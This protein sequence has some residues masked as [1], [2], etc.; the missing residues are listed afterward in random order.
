MHSTLAASPGIPNFVSPVCLPEFESTL[1][2]AY[3]AQ[4]KGLFTCFVLFA[5]FTLYLALA[6]QNAMSIA[7]FTITFL[8]VVAIAFDAL[9]LLRDTEALK[10]RARFFCWIQRSPAGRR[11]AHLWLSL[12]ISLGLLQLILQAHYGGHEQLVLALG[13]HF[14]SIRS[15]QYWRTLTGPYFHSG[16][17]HFVNNAILLMFIGPISWSM[18][19][20]KS[21]IAFALGNAIGVLAQMA[22]GLGTYDA[23]L[24]ISPGVFSLFGMVIASGLTQPKRWPHGFILLCTWIALLSLVLSSVLSTNAANVSHIVGLLVGLAILL[25]SQFAVRIGQSFRPG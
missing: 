6:R 20:Y 8:I 10:D 14:E 23:F 2:S 11:A 18:L 7:L 22:F 16:V 15:G 21:L 17:V 19:G 4:V 5:C 25:V 1:R 9:L 12:L 3:I 13:A 24:G